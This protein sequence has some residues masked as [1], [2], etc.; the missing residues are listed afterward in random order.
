M[1]VEQETLGFRRGSLSLPLS[2]LMSAFALLIPPASLTGHLRRPTER[3]PTIQESEVRNRE[4]V[5]TY[6]RLLLRPCSI[7][8]ICSYSSRQCFHF[9]SSIYP[10]S[11]QYRLHTRISSAEPI[12]ISMKR[13]NSAWD[14]LLLP[15]PSAK[16]AQMLLLA[17]LI[18]SAKAYC[19][20]FG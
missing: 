18:W 19:S 13:L 9:S 5:K 20:T 11:R 10:K 17:R 15:Y 6:L 4:S 8:A 2:L 3:S 14:R 16:F 7:L 12:L 1:N